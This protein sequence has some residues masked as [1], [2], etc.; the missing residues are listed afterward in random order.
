MGRLMVGA[1]Y[2]DRLSPHTVLT[3]YAR[4]LIDTGYMHRHVTGGSAGELGIGATYTF[5][6]RWS[7]T[8]RAGYRFQQRTSARFKSSFPTW[9]LAVGYSPSSRDAL[10]LAVVNLPTRFAGFPDARYL[11]LAWNHGFRPGLSMQ[12]Y[13]T[14]GLAP[15]SPDYGVGIG[16]MFRLY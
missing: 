10:Q 12:F 7:A 5:V 6:H 11:S 13:A 9:E 4:A 3:P 16:G 15:T 1:D 2:Y 14:A 8:A